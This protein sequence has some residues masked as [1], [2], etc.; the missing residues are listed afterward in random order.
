VEG[1]DAALGQQHLT[2]VLGTVHREHVS[3]LRLVD[4]EG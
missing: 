4:P 1:F 3:I 2:P